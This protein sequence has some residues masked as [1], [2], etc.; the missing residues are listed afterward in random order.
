MTVKKKLIVSNILM[1][2][3]PALLALLFV[4]VSFKTVGNRYWESMEEMYDDKS[5][6]Y[7]A[8]SILFAY[9]NEIRDRSD[10]EYHESEDGTMKVSLEKTNVMISLE[11]ELADLGYHFRIRLDDD[12]LWSNITHDEHE[13]MEEYLREKYRNT[14][15]L[16]LS[17]NDLSIVKNTFENDGKLFELTAVQVQDGE[18]D[19]QADSYF[20]KYIM[21]FIFWF[22]LFLVVAILIVNAALSGW[23]VRSIMHPLNILKDG[24]RR[25]ADGDLEWEL[26]YHNKDEFGEVCGEF[27]RMRG[28]LKESVE[29]RIQYEQY[30]RELIA[31]ISHDLR[32]PLTSIK[33]YTEG[34]QDGIA[35][36]PEKQKR[37]SL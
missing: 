27:D 7:S 4:I 15:A 13:L 18:Q 12:V 1:I 26:D 28:H 20:R 10:L 36:T 17:E 24:T 8:Q 21:T 23:I 6:I 31:G 25:I 34:L 35:D 2:V 33:G 30:R 9:K 22:L 19:I 37:F 5:G 14:G 16:T 32:T 11:Q 3:I 29:T